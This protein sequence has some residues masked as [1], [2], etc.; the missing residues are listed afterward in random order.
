MIARA[1][2]PTPPGHFEED[3]RIGFR[4]VEKRLDELAR[5]G[6]LPVLLVCDIAADLGRHRGITLGYIESALEAKI[7]AKEGIPIEHW[8]QACFMLCPELYGE[9]PMP[10][11]PSEAIPRSRA[12]VMALARRFDAGNALRNPRDTHGLKAD[13]IPP[14]LWTAPMIRAAQTEESTQRKVRPTVKALRVR[15]LLATKP[16]ATLNELATYAGCSH[17]TVKKFLDIEKKQNKGNA[18]QPEPNLIS[19]ILNLAN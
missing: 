3:Q 15:E 13:Q 11:R 12:F 4:E 8:A 9:P 16:D 18:S 7:Q 19:N 6:L 1:P 17:S 2:K 10:M 5:S 14:E